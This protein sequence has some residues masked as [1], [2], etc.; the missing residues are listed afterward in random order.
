M[1][2]GRITSSW[3]SARG[4]ALVREARVWGPR[5]ALWVLWPPLRAGVARALFSDSPTAGA[6]PLTGVEPLTDACL[7]AD[8]RLRGLRLSLS[9]VW[10][11]APEV[12]PAEKPHHA[13]RP[14][15]HSHLRPA[16][17]GARCFAEMGLA[18]ALR[19]CRRFRPLLSLR[20][21]R[22]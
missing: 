7:L 3:V 18:P 19:Q 13:C 17:H 6:G 15:M 22:V 9:G 4:L 8:A 11:L 14:G 21:V 16:M 12:L 2:L 1:I 10:L 20:L 5:L